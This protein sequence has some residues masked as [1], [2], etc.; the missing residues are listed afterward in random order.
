MI[1]K[2]LAHVG[3]EPQ[4]KALLRTQRSM[5]QAAQHLQRGAV[6][7]RRSTWFGVLPAQRIR[8]CS[9]RRQLQDPASGRRARDVGP[10]PT[11]VAPTW[12]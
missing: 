7:G 4:I 10:E 8:F 6:I 11:R 12:E 1:E 3:L 5:H 9:L 2:I